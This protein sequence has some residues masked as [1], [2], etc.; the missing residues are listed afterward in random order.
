VPAALRRGDVPF[1][2]ARTKLQVD[3]VHSSLEGPWFDRQGNL[4][5]S[6]I[7][8]GRIFSISP[9][10]DSRVLADYDG[11]P[12]GLAI[13]PDGTV[14]IA[15]YEHGLL[16]LEP[17]TEEPRSLAMRYNAERFRGLS[18]LVVAASG[19]VYFTDQGQSDLLRPTGRV[20]RYRDGAGV[21]LL[22]SGLPDRPPRGRRLAGSYPT[23]ANQAGYMRLGTVVVVY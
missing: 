16:A 5:V 22:L 20:F 11:K 2:W 18:G 3:S 19:M 21:E 15:D 17:G 12:N 13:R 1:E 6:D 23:A 8:Y 7:P 10:G 14:L 9:A 4:L